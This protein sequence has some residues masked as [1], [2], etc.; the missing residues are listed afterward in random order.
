MQKNLIAA[1]V[2]G[3]IIFIWQFLSWTV[4]QL[5][6]PAQDY[7]PNQQEILQYLDGQLQEGGYLLPNTPP[8]ASSD[9]M[10]AAMEEMDGKP[11]AVIQYHK[12]MNMSMTSG[13]V[14]SL[15]TDIITVLLLCIVLS[16]YVKRRFGNVFMASLLTGIIVFLNI[17]YT[18][19]IWY[20]TFDLSAHLI[21]ALAS[22]GLCGLWLGWFYGRTKNVSY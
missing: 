22:W 12:A 8:N 6:R 13:I 19:H 15:V 1:V 10:N 3:I 18:T 14:R 21:D 20:E 9:E 7:T 16:G 17:P 5:H 4:L 11:W 2:G